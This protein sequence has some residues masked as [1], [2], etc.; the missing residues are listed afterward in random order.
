M[1]NAK[2]CFGSDIVA[3]SIC[4]HKTRLDTRQWWWRVTSL[5]MLRATTSLLKQPFALHSFL[6]RFSPEWVR[7]RSWKSQEIYIQ[8]CIGSLIKALLQR[9]AVVCSPTCLTLSQHVQSDKSS[10]TVQSLLLHSVACE[11][12][13][14]TQLFRNLEFNDWKKPQ[15]AATAVWEYSC[16]MGG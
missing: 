2:G 7:K 12:N 10:A 16:Q 8:N 15:W 13:P 3:Q 5:H 11:T 14:W 4:S 1:E 9:A 6:Q